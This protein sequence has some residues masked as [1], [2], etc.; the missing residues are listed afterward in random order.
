MQIAASFVLLAGAGMLLTTLLELQTTQL[1]LNT[2]NVLA[3]H[4]PVI[5]G[6]RAR[7]G[8]GLLPRGAAP[9]RGASRCRARRGRHARA[10]ARGRRF[11]PRVP[12][13]GRGLR[14]G[15][16]RR[17][18]ARAVPHRLARILRRSRR[19]AHRRARLQRRRTGATPRR[20]SSSARAWRSGCSRTRMRSIAT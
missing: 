8:H 2:S 6:P 9:D 10:V 13:L 18:S 14:Q 19:A 7:A 4:V 11:R 17:R 1:R 12:V 20:S 15:R 16:R 3:L 5:S